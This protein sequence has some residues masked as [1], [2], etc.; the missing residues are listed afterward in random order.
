MSLAHLLSSPTQLLATWVVVL[1]PLPHPLSLVIWERRHLHALSP[2][3]QLLPTLVLA[4]PLSVAPFS[5]APLFA[6]P[7]SAAQLPV[8]PVLS[9]RP[10]LLHR[11]SA[12]GGADWMPSVSTRQIP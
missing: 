11:P 6:A 10:S 1:L 4:A 5:A 7:R 12:V 2:V 3:L 9:H 8:P